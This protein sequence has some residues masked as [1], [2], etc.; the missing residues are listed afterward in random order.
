MQRAVPWLICLAAGMALATSVAI[1][2]AAAASCKTW[3]ASMT[4]DEGGPV[5]TADVCTADTVGA[6]A[7]ELQCSGNPSLRYD[8]GDKAGADL[9][10][11]ISAQFSFTAG[12]TSVTRKL[13]LEAMDNM[14]VIDF[15]PA[16]SLLTLL[17]SGHEVSIADIS[18]KYGTNSFSLS[19]S[20]AA[21]AKVLASCNVPTTASDDG[22]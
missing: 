17:Q 13:D 5:M 22:D 14:F 18:G 2:P 12:T 8:L 19:G 4:D 10:P 7:L 6:P 15:K 16:D 1:A 20:R 9:E 21:I 11:G 3:D